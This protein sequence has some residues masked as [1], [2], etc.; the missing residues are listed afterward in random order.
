MERTKVQWEGRRCLYR[1]DKS[2]GDQNRHQKFAL[3]AHIVHNTLPCFTYL[4]RGHTRNNMKERGKQ[5]QDVSCQCEF[6]PIFRHF[7]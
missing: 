3:V 4:P 6:G 7:C 1:Q 2:A 5:E